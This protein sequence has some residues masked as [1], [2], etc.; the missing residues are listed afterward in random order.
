MRQGKI[1]STDS[2][3]YN[4]SLDEIMQEN[5]DIAMR[6]PEVHMLLLWLSYKK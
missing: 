4:C 3:T 2:E 1:A 6:S 5:M